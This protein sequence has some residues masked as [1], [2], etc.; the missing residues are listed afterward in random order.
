VSPDIDVVIIGAGAAGLAAAR[1]LER[2]GKHIVCLEAR[3]RIGGRILTA[4]DPLTP[5][6]VEMGAEFVHG[7]PSESFDLIRAADLTVYEVGGRM[8]GGGE[9]DRIMED[10]KHLP[11]D[12]RDESLRQFL[13][14][15]DY[16]DDEKHAAVSFIEGFDAARA[17]RIGV[18]GLARDE[19]AADRIEGDRSF[20]ILNGYDSLIHALGTST[21]RLNTVV[22][23]VNW[24]PGTCSVHVR[25][26]LTEEHETIQATRVLIT[27]PL[28][29]LQAGSIRFDPEPDEILRAARALDYGDVYRVTAR[30]ECPFW[31]ENPELSGAAFIF[32][33]EDVFPT[34]WTTHPV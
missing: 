25:S 17:E 16:S 34:W 24:R 31:E 11:G 19:R 30:F 28:G 22:D 15:H 27:A 21:V 3:E 8:V 20:R 6:P 29:C 26:G 13:E 9:P 10:I 18:S 4:H 2:A 33:D 32:S 12:A 1:E 5:V 23:C 7:R 14:K